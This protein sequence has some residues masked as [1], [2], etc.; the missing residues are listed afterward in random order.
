MIIQKIEIIIIK[1]INSDHH[2]Y[3]YRLLSSFSSLTKQYANAD[4]S[5]FSPR[6]HI[7]NALA[8]VCHLTVAANA[9]STGIG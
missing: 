3:N 1:T 2:L 5:A 8:S 7:E 4:Q 9:E 6:P